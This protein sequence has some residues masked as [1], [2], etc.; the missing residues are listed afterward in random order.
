MTLFGTEGHYPSLPV[1]CLTEGA[2]DAA[3]VWEVGCP[4]LG[5]YGSGLHAPQVGLLVR[6]NPRLIL[7]VFDMDDA[8]E[9]ATTRAFSQ[10]SRVAEIQRVRWTGGKDPAECTKVN[11]RSALLRAVGR[12]QYGVDVVPR[13]D[14]TIAEMQE[15]YH[16]HLEEDTY[17]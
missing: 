17:A 15:A 4:A 14:G 11:R 7:I 5:V 6:Y 13:W 3:S 12:S 9:N 8:G 10:L 16:R 1:I 2:A